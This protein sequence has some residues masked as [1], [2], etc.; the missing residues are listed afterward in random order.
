MKQQGVSLSQ[1]LAL[2]IIGVVLVVYG[3]MFWLGMKETED[4]E[5]VEAVQVKLQHAV[6]KGSTV[7]QLPPRQIHPANIVN[8]VRSSFP[9]GA[10]VDNNFNLKLAHSD[11]GAQY[12]ITPE[13][14]LVIAS[15]ENF[16]RYR[17]EKGR[18][19]RNNHWLM[20][21]LTEQPKN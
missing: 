16:T 18:I 21:M 9:E 7:L 19:V 8:S 10:Q 11:R 4:A 12:R 2:G 3:V 17:V 5:I 1:T 20:P 15:L 6:S 13:G 14:D